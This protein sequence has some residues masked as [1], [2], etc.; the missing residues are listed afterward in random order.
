MRQGELRGVSRRDGE[1]ISREGHNPRSAIIILFDISLIVSIRL[2]LYIYVFSFLYSIFWS[3]VNCHHLWDVGDVVHGAPQVLAGSLS[4]IDWD[5]LPVQRKQWKHGI[6]CTL[7]IPSIVFFPNF[8]TGYMSPSAN[9]AIARLKIIKM[10]WLDDPRF[11][12][13]YIALSLTNLIK[14]VVRLAARNMRR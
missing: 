11:H 7:Y 9:P 5:H 8:F 4:H 2:T 1:K 3:F 6:M 10:F 12:L 14:T 13:R